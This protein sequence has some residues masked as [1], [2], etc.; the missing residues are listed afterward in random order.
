MLQHYTRKRV[1]GVAAN[2]GTALPGHVQQQDFGVWIVSKS[3]FL[4]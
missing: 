4:K 1:S 2:I 3:D